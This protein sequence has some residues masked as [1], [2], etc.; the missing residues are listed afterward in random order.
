M[1]LHN[2][3]YTK[4]AFWA[5]ALNGTLCCRAVVSSGEKYGTVFMGQKILAPQRHLRN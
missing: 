1:V 5:G 3:E 2:T 4:K